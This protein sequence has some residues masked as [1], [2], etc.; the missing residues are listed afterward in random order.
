MS[1]PIELFY[2]RALPGRGEP[3]RLLLED[4][5]AAYVDMAREPGGMH[6]LSAIK[7]QESPGVAPFAPPFVR[8][9]DQIIAQT[10]AIMHFLGMRFGL[11]PEGEAERVAGLQHQITL[12]DVWGEVHHVHHP[13]STTLYFEEQRDVAIEAAQ[14]FVHGRLQK[15]LDYFERVLS[16]RP[17]LVGEHSHVDLTMF[18]TLRGLA[19]MFPRAFDAHRASVPGLMALE[20]RVASRP[21]VASYLASDRRMAFNEHGIFRGYAELDVLPPSA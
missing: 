9:G 19:H 2:W 6:M 14:S 18:Q 10:P 12:A 13:V 15:W 5:G 17:G 7:D 16:G 8:I 3:I 1:D 11:A 21:G 4:A 20:A